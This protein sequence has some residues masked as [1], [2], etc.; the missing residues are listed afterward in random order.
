MVQDVRRLSGEMDRVILVQDGSERER[1]YADVSQKQTALA[2]RLKTICNDLI[3]PDFGLQG[4]PDTLRRLCADFGKRSGIA[5]RLEIAEGTAGQNTGL[6]F[7]GREKLLQVF[8]IVQ[9]ALSNVEKHSNAGEAVVVLR[10]EDDGSF[11]V[12]VSDNG[13]GIKT[14]PESTPGARALGIGA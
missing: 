1:L 4:L 13:G 10:S 11:S 7:L 5:C 14:R 6:D 2:D 9:E 12:I 8:R 3:P